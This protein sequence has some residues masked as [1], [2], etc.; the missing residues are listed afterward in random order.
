M[1][2]NTPNDIFYKPSLG[3]SGSAEKALFDAKLDSADGLINKNKLHR[4]GGFLKKKYNGDGSTVA[5]ATDYKFISGS[6]L[7]FVD[8]ILREEGSG[9]DYTEDGD[10]LGITFPTAPAS[11]E[12]I[13][14]RSVRD[15]D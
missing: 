11:D 13:E 8:G 15:F 7:V 6:T 4:Q 2:E 12:K 14:I 9:N 10:C 5:F 3:A 1:G